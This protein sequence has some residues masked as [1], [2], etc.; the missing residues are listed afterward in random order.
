M[1][2]KEDNKE[3]ALKRVQIYLILLAF[4]ISSTGISTAESTSS[5]Y[6][7]VT[8]EIKGVSPASIGVD[9]EF[10]VGINLHSCGGK[11]PENITFEIT[12]IPP[13][14]I[15][16]ENFV[17]NIPKLYYGSERYLVYHMR[18]TPDAKPG[19]HIIKMKLTYGNE[20]FKSE[21][22]YQVEVRVTGE[23]AEPGIS[24]VK[25]NPDYIY[26]G[27][28][29]DLTLDIK[30]FGKTIAKS[31]LISLDHEFKGI[32]NNTIGTIGVNESQ[33]VLF[34]FKA[35]KSGEFKI[36]VIIEY[37]DDFGKQ[38]HEYELKFTVLDKKERLNIASFKVDPS[39]PYIDDTVELTMRVENSGNRTINSIRVYVDHP[40]KGLKESFIGTLDPNEDGPAVITFIPDKAGEYELPVTITY[41]DDF[42]EAQIKT[43]V[44]FIVLERNNAA[45]SV[46]IGLLILAVI[47]GLIYYNYKTK[48][49][50]DK[51]IKQL[52]EG[53][54]D[55]ADIK[56]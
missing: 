47:G 49:S 45:G 38:R 32:K 31:V 21:T 29:V 28:T 33:T 44:N 7:C 42:G 26:E 5:G 12:S 30:N 41:S 23:Y 35:D 8:A 20:N 4:A 52:M 51:I 37:E 34:K 3:K 40:F 43:K 24:S 22:Y 13:D 27:D 55:S 39:L 46:L 25:T 53:S 18:T 50:K 6:D 36:P 10:T 56:K 16:I 54:G 15:V 2:K 11:V 17:T 1:Q 9:E 14:I 19:P 48:K